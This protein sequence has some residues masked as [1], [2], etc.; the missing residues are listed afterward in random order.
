LTVT[1]TTLPGDGIGPEVTAEALRILQT[2]SKKIGLDICCNEHLIGGAAIDEFNVPLPAK[3]LQACKESDA[4]FLGAVGGPKW[5]DIEVHL[6]PE[7]GLLDLRKSL[8]LFA[9]LRPVSTQSGLA[10]LTPF[11]K[12]HLSNLNILVI[13]ELTGGLYFGKR[14]RTAHEAFDTCKYTVPEIERVARLA[15]KLATKRTRKITSVDKA[16]VLDT[17]RL[18]RDTVSRVINDE[19]PSV[20]LEHI[21][22]DAAAM[23]LI[24]QPET[25]D[26]LLTENM[27]GDILSDEASM[28]AGSLGL[29]PSASLGQ[30]K[31]GLFEPIHGSA[32]DIAGQNIANPVGAILSIEMMLRHS[33][34]QADAANALQLAV[35]NVLSNGVLTADLVSDGQKPASTIEFGDAVLE[36]IQL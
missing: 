18:W 22:V 34:K 19:F 2:I 35:N 36:D 16:N 32:P 13:R 17:S 1:V 33:F 5:K 14:N 6:R 3:T 29:L 26:V 15:G 10:D 24:S 7:Q 31:P 20:T 21:Y 4:I 25:F 28:L 11:K 23:Y 12:G 27:F 30:N 9:N 8:E